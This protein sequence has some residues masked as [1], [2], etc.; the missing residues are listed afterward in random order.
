MPR[1]GSD[2]SVATR[3]PSARTMASVASLEPPSMTICSTSGWDCAFT[4][5]SVSATVA[6]LLRVTV[7][8]LI[9]MSRMC[10][11]RPGSRPVPNLLCQDKQGKSAE[12][13]CGEI[14]ADGRD[15]APRKIRRQTASGTAGRRVQCEVG[16]VIVEDGVAGVLEGRERRLGVK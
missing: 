12:Q 10:W 9:F 1:S 6:A 2:T 14:A 13:S 8:R 7:M 5:R 4:D 11:S 16:E 3:L 15:Q